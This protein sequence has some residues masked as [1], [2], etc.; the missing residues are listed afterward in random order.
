MSP[1]ASQLCASIR[2]RT[3]GCHMP[4]FAMSSTI[5]TIQRTRRPRPR[6]RAL[7]FATWPSR[8]CAGTADRRSWRP[9]TARPRPRS[10]PRAAAAPC[11]GAR[12]RPATFCSGSE[13]ASITGASVMCCWRAHRV[14]R[15]AQAVRRARQDERQ[16]RSARRKRTSAECGELVARRV[17]SGS[18]QRRRAIAPSRAASGRSG[19]GWRCRPARRPAIPR[20]GRSSPPGPSG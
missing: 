2:S 9:A 17:R 11:R 20:P 19:T 14:E 18:C 3:V 4:A 6:A 5:S 12:S 10:R 15:G 13:S 8:S 16:A 7:R 1:R